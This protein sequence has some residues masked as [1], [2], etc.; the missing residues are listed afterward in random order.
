MTNHNLLI[1]YRI[2]TVTQKY[3]MNSSKNSAIAY[4]SAAGRLS[5]AGPVATRIIA[6]NDRTPD[7]Q[8][9]NPASLSSKLSIA[10]TRETGGI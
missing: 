2:P 4:R 3:S 8:Q 1:P 10:S 7:Y 6:A 5:L 9:T